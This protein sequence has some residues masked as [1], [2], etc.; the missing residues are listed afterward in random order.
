VAEIKTPPF[1]PKQNYK[2]KA[3]ISNKWSIDFHPLVQK[4]DFSSKVQD[5]S[6]R[7]HF[8]NPMLAVAFV[9]VFWRRLI[10]QNKVTANV[11]VFMK[12]GE[13]W[14]RPPVTGAGFCSKVE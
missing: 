2:L 8:A 14:T 10:R 5:F 1:K 13:F 9:F 3:D 7:R 12:K 6:S 4:L 11:Q